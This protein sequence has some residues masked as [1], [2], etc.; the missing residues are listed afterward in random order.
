MLDQRG[1]ALD[2]GGLVRQLKPEQ[3]G[4]LPQG[5]HHRGPEGETEH[6]RMG[7]KIHQRAEAQHAQQP[8]EQPGDKCEQQDKRDVVIAAWYG[9]GADGGVEHDGNSCRRAADQVPGRTPQAS[10]HHRDDRRIEA[11][12]GGQA[13]NQCIGDGLWQGKDRPAQPHQQVATDAGAGLA[14]QPG[15]ERQ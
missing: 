4:Q 8:L 3:V 5:N 2:G 13:G 1:Q 9:Q 7:D 6:D 10:D 11:I 15:Q 12:F 14:W